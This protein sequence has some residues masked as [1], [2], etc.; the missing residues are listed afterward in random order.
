MHFQTKEDGKKDSTKERDR[1]GWSGYQRANVHT[2]NQEDDDGMRDVIRLDSGT[3][4]SLFCN[5]DLVTN[6]PESK[7]IMNL[8]T[9][10]GSKLIS[11]EATVNGFGTVKFDKESIAI[12]FGLQDLV[13]RYSCLLYTSPSPRDA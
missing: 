4:I 7:T 6:V 8:A 12:I 9:N 1:D 3:T 2:Q 11:E 5:E 13:E 10:A